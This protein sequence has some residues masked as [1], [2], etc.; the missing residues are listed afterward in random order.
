MA[1]TLA[2]SRI[3]RLRCE[4]G[5]MMIEALV[6]AA[7]MLG[8]G[9]ATIAAYDSTTRASH[10]AER[11]AEAVAIAE[12]EMERIVS[13][14]YAQINDCVAPGAGTGRVDDPNSW[15]QG[16]R[17]FVAANFRPRGGYATPPAVDL[18]AGNRVALED[19][20]VANTTGCVQ[21]QEDA[22]SVGVAGNS[23]IT[24]TKIFRFVTYQGQQCASNLGATMTN[25]LASS[26]LA[27]TTQATL[28]TTAGADVA[29]LCAAMAGQQA[30]RVTIAVVL[31]QV[32]NG[33]GL[34][35]PVYLSTLIPSPN[36]S[37]H[38]GTGT[39]LG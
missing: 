1:R 16:T 35:Y 26:S 14:P 7:I 20:A 37:L 6:A 36:A 39:V 2:T 22:S 21:P 23:K 3:D 10:T 5:A 17:L 32:D 33:A 4:A 15:V 28:T 27:G 11:E 31:N 25:S 24:H 38:A 30:K 29:A 9:A 8:G 12:Q 19:F 13:K 18:S 34:K